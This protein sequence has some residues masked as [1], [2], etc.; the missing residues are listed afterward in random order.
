MPWRNATFPGTLVSPC[1]YLFVILLTLRHQAATHYTAQGKNDK[2]AEVLGAG[3][4]ACPS[5]PLLT[6]AVAEI[7]EGRNNFARCHEVFE[8]LVNKLDPEIEVLKE[9]IEVEVENAKGPEIPQPQSGDV[10]MTGDS[11]SEVQRLVEERENRGNLVAE[12]R[13]KDVN[14]LAAAIGVVWVMYMRFARRAEVSR[15][16]NFVR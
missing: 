4:E 11:M 15:V 12:R 8:G 7:E 6:F 3:I 1:T 13:G 5:S 16:S 14:D 2:A 10:D 9:K